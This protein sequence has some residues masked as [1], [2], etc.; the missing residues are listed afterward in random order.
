MSSNTN[1]NELQIWNNVIRNCEGLGTC[2]IGLAFVV[3]PQILVKPLARSQ[4]T[5]TTLRISDRK[6]QEF[7]ARLYGLTTF[8]FGGTLYVLS[9]GADKKKRRLTLQILAIGDMA[10]L[11]SLFV[12]DEL[13][14]SFTISQGCISLILLGLRT[15][16][17][18]NL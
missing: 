3:A 6:N 4:S 1:N 16:S 5:M 11:A 12:L 9:E 8:V 2:V 10:H 7:L 15:Y 18:M 14:S 17:L 13:H